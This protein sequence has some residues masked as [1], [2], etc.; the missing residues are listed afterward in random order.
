MRM[1]GGGVPARCWS[2]K[3]KRREKKGGKGEE[4]GGGERG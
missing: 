2:L 3:R 1:R 4:R